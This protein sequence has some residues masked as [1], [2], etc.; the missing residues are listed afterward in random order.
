MTL[1]HCPQLC[2]VHYLSGSAPRAGLE[3]QSGLHDSAELREGGQVHSMQPPGLAQRRFI[4]NEQFPNKLC[5][6]KILRKRK[7]Q[8]GGEPAAAQPV[9]GDRRATRRPGLSPGTG[10]G[11]VTT[12]PSPPSPEGTWHHRP[13]SVSVDRPLLYPQSPA[14]G[15]SAQPAV[16]DPCTAAPL[17]S[18]PAAPLA[19][20]GVFLSPFTPPNL[21]PLLA[22][23]EG[24]N[25]LHLVAHGHPACPTP[26]LSWARRTSGPILL[27]T[28]EEQKAARGS[29][30]GHRSPTILCARGK[31]GQ[32]RGN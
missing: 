9:H 3:L 23:Q 4:W 19:P 16:C 31:L 5:N 10:R 26:A 8:K 27:K 29:D 13:L 32:G 21:H 20:R 1:C 7:R 12:I 14:A 30:P 18:N 2:P 28:A 24:E 11:S 6:L 22:L 25:R 15:L 17:H